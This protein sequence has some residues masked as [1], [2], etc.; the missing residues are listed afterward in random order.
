M[1]KIK[2]YVYSKLSAIKQTNEVAEYAKA[3]DI[4][5]VELAKVFVYSKKDYIEAKATGRV[6]KNDNV[7]IYARF[8][9]NNQNEISI[10]GQLDSCFAHCAKYNLHI[11]AIYVDMAQ[12]A[13]NDNRVAFQRLNCDVLEE[14]HNGSRMLVYSNSRF[15]RNRSDSVFYRDF[16]GRFGIELDSVTEICP[17]GKD[18]T[19]IT[20]IRE[21]MD[22]HYSEDLAINVSRGLRQR[23]Q[24]CQ[25]T[26]GMVTYGYK[27]NPVTRLY[28]IC[29]P[30]AENVRMVFKMYVAKQ[31]YAEI[32]KELDKRGA[33][34]RSGRPFSK[35]V[36]GDMVTNEKYMGIYTYNKRTGRN[37]IGE[38]N[39]HTYKDDSEVVRVPGGIP[40]IVD[41]QSF[42]AGTKPSILL[43]DALTITRVV[44]A[45]AKRSIVTIWKPLF[46]TL[47][48]N[49]L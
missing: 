48:W 21:V 42:L 32:L 9:S 24:M 27:V 13:R 30:E 45:L 10:T 15:A 34:C 26:G 44:N 3:H 39:S 29:E 49:R 5:I 36:L 25:Y 4:E 6:I 47:S 43:I 40:A 17:R 18:G 41:E 23:A 38:R 7:V 1:E 16:Y 22:Q 19:F 31:G 14:Y 46:W 12:T 8:S 33:V 11:K 28:E 37:S 20:S 35:N 2:M